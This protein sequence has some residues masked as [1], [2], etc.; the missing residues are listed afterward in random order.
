M[1]Q[2]PIHITRICNATVLIEIGDHVIL[3][4]PYFINVPFFRVTELPAMQAKDLPP[5]T[6]ILGCHDVG[7]HWQMEGLAD[8]PHDKSEVPIF[9]AMESQAKSAREH[10]FSRVE[11]LP[12]GQSRD[13]G[14]GLCIQSVEAQKM[15]RWTVNNYLITCGDASVFFGSEARDLPP[16]KA[17]GETRKETDVALFPV[18]GV[19]MMGMQ[20]VMKA[21][22]AVQGAKLIGAKK[23]FVIH[24]WHKAFP[25]LMT[26]A[27][28]GADAEA[29]AKDD[30]LLDVIR[31]G[32]GERWSYA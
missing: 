18:N 8:Y 23:L 17:F 9:V 7:D 26:A 30:D 20:L 13:L 27:T 22:E 28:S 4:D 5:L 25:L 10:G 32:A 31:V 24:D 1:P 29:A 14:G 11:V 3:T 6:A 2:T 21:H 15:M 12:W 16:L 19:R